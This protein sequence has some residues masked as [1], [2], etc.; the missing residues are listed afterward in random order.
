MGYYT[1]YTLGIHKHKFNVNSSAVTVEPEIETE[2]AKALA[3]IMYENADPKWLDNI[4][5]LYDVLNDSMKWYDHEAEMSQLSAIF[6]DYYFT[7]E[8]DGEESDDYWRKLF[9]NGGCIGAVDGEIYYPEFDI[10][11]WDNE[12]EDEV[13]ETTSVKN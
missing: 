8:G 7:L 13:C 3:K 9:H 12:D 4:N 5:D 11:Y 2:V 1:Y 6:P 10:D